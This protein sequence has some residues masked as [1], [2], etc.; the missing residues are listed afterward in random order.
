MSMVNGDGDGECTRECTGT[1]HARATIM[2]F[3]GAEPPQ[4]KK[5]SASILP[6]K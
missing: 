3:S 1:G 5:N 6:P 4:L 2:P